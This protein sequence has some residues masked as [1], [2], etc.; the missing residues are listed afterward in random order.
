MKGMGIFI[1]NCRRDL[2]RLIQVSAA[3]ALWVLSATATA[4]QLPSAKAVQVQASVQPGS[5]AGILCFVYSV[6]NPASNSVSVDDFAIDISN[7][8]GDA[9]VNAQ[10][11]TDG[12]GDSSDFSQ[13]VLASGRAIPMI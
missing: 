12:A 4:Q 5:E 7:R 13:P 1:M 3:L 9:E 8:P 2:S 11:V 10:G 6:S